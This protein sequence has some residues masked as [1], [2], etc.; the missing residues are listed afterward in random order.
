MVVKESKIIHELFEEQA[1]RTPDKKAVIFRQKSLSY[2]E[3]NIKSNRLAAKLREVNVKPNDV[4]A[5]V[6]NRSIDLLVGILGILKAGACYLP[7]DPAYPKERISYILGDSQVALMLTQRELAEEIYFTGQTLCVDDE[8]SYTGDGAVVEKVNSPDDLIYILYTSGST[9]K[10]KG[11]MIEHKAVFNFIEGIASIINFAEDKSIVCVTTIAFDIFLLETL[12]PLCK[13]LQVVLAD[14]MSLFQDVEGHRVDMMQTT[15]ST[16]KLLL[17][18]ERNL[19][20]IKGLSEI[21]L[22]G[23]SFPKRLLLQLKEFTET[24]NIYNMYGPTETTIWSAV[25]DLTHTEEITIG[26]PIRHTELYIL[27]EHLNQV[28]TGN[29]GELYISGL[30]VARGYVNKPELTRERFIPDPV[31]PGQSMYKTGDL[32][33]W[34]AN[35]EAE[36]HGRTDNQVKIRGS[37]IE[38]EEIEECLCL[39]PLLQNCVVTAKENHWGGKYLVAYYVSDVEVT[40]SDLIHFL[41]NK[42]PE[43]MIPGFY[44]RID[45]VPL[46]PNGKTD[47]NKLPEPDMRRPALATEYV[48]PQTDLEIQISDLWRQVLACE[49][50]GTHDNFF[51]LGGNSVLISLLAVKVNELFPGQIVVTDLFSNPTIYK[52]VQFLQQKKSADQGGFTRLKLPLEYCRQEDEEAA[53]IVLQSEI[54]PEVYLKLRLFMQTKKQE[55]A[56][57]MLAL[58]AHILS[59]VSEQDEI[60]IVVNCDWQRADTP[61]CVDLA[62]S[63]D[64]EVVLNQINDQFKQ[65]QTNTN[66]L[67]EE[68]VWIVPSFCVAKSRQLQEPR[69]KSKLMLTVY[70]ETE[71]LA[72]RLEFHSRDL[73]K[74]KIYDLFTNYVQLLT[75]VAHSV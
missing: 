16:M 1:A 50:V 53:E 12:L 69:R 8:S 21:M 7:I 74:S 14:P 46:T 37:R 55:L 6:M 66:D 67:L 57:L 45:Q 33:R 63:S 26:S 22:G 40:V 17:Q 13:G 62:A 54:E 47:R 36:F 38:L 3:L 39:H 35:G 59:E 43:S 58:F 32:A 11:V 9:G 60:G 71:G 61:I 30:G 68:G 28:T 44:V 42:L 24:A 73:A 51:E 34:L 10:P 2:A 75:A 15:P 52:L 29:I 19:E 20:I 49:V 72:C 41:S 23:E 25:K 4:V 5:L 18:D 56:T 48:E 27:D 64:L 31:Y 65:A 70:Q